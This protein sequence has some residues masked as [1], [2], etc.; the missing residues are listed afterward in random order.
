MSWEDLKNAGRKKIVSY[1]ALFLCVSY[2]MS[3]CAISTAIN[4]TTIKIAIALVATVLFSAIGFF[5]HT[6]NLKED[7]LDAWT[8]LFPEYI[9]WAMI[10]GL[11]LGLAYHLYLNIHNTY[12][13][14]S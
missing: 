14:N 12:A 5:I 1:I 7:L 8:E 13:E 6:F 10:I 3:V 11:T 4:P 9:Y 2:L